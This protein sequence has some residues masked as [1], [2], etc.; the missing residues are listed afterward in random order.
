MS[1]VEKLMKFT[2][3]SWDTYILH[4]DYSRGDWIWWEFFILELL[5]EKW[6]LGSQHHFVYMDRSVHL[7]LGM[8]TLQIMPNILFNWK[9]M[10]TM[11]NSLIL[12]VG[13]LNSYSHLWKADT[14]IP[15]P[16]LMY[17]SF[18]SAPRWLMHST[19]ERRCPIYLIRC[20]D[21]HWTWS[22]I[23]AASVLK[24]RKSLITLPPNHDFF[25]KD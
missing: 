1:S 19:A 23:Y 14:C 25:T 12:G 5:L 11:I 17:I 6:T 15:W 24:S 22:F 21:C 10:W 7:P 4:P 8:I 13:L 20:W 16:C 9:T 3:A 18:S 2:M